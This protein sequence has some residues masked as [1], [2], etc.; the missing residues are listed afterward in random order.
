M[1]DIFE[2]WVRIF[3]QP[4][5]FYVLVSKREKACLSWF[6][7]VLVY[8]VVLREESSDPET[9]KDL[10]SVGLVQLR[11]AEQGN[12]QG[13]ALTAADQLPQSIKTMR[14]VEGPDD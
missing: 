7:E 5:L 13:C 3:S 10:F 8:S 11:S 4:D 12:S 9:F 2:L 14:N 6:G 1:K